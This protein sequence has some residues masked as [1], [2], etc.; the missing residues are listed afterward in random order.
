MSLIALTCSVVIVQPLLLAME[1]LFYPPTPILD[2]PEKIGVSIEFRKQVT[3]VIASVVLFFVVYLL[4]VIASVGLAIGCFYAGIAIIIAMPK[5]ITLLLGIGLIAVG[6]S[7]FFFLIKFIFAVSKNENPARIEIKEKDQPRLFAFIRKLTADTK[8][9]FPKKIYV[10]PDVNAC[11]FYNSSFWS[12]FFPVRKNLEIGL[13]LVNSINISEFKAVLAHEFG[14]FSQQSMKLGSFTYN[15][16]RI[17]YNML[18]DNSSYSKFISHWANLSGWLSVFASITIKI[19]QGIQW[20]LKGMYRIVNKNYYSMS[21]EMEYHADA[22][23]ASVSGGDNLINALRR[24]EVASSCYQTAIDEANAQIK[25]K[26]KAKNIFSNQLVVFKSIG[27]L[28]NLPIVQGLPVISTQFLN[29]FAKS[30]II[31]KDQWASHPTLEER[32]KK[33]DELDIR[34]DAMERSAWEVF[35]NPEL[36]QEKLTKNLYHSLDTDNKLES[37]DGAHFEHSLALQQKEYLLPEV[38]NGFY[39]ERFFDLTDWNFESVC[40]SVSGLKFEEIFNIDNSKLH[41]SIQNNEGD[42]E[43]VKAIKEKRL[44]VK[45]FDFDGKKYLANQSDEVIGIIQKEIDSSKDLLAR[46][47]KEAYCFFYKNARISKDRL[48]GNYEEF[49]ANSVWYEDFVELVNKALNSLEPL[50]HGSLTIEQAQSIIGDVKEIYEP[51]LK[52]YYKQFLQENIFVNASDKQI[53]EQLQ[54]FVDSDYA[55]FIDNEFVNNELSDFSN[56]SIRAANE[57]NKYRFRTYKKMLEEQLEGIE[58]L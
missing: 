15:T 58:V 55:Y 24:L 31:F 13:G 12:M 11:V 44:D 21:R 42:I 39:K 57:F 40:N 51:K 47:D 52:D 38:Y 28:Y 43:L 8:T 4:L 30:R 5:I 36:L 35:D 10:S 7:V 22:V 23:A 20:I 33:L 46:L 1:N 26:K 27:R 32:K 45:T 54:K 50:Y 25:E 17:I 6:V 29:S 3:K 37:Y 16:N 48:R 34:I 14:H 19:A 18:F 53:I 9:P 41:E 49:R 56:L 2:D